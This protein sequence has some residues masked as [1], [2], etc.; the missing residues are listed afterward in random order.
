VVYTFFVKVLLVFT[1]RKIEY[2]FTEFTESIDS[3]EARYAIVPYWTKLISNRLIFQ[4]NLAC[5]Q[6]EN[7]FYDC[8]VKKLSKVIKRVLNHVITCKG[9][10]GEA[11]TVEIVRLKFNLHSFRKFPPDFQLSFL[12]PRN[13]NVMY[14]SLLPMTVNF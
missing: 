7:G 2:C 10:Y 9:F 12:N 4:Q 11:K 3:T 8:V 5:F 1:K 13:A 6:V 14:S